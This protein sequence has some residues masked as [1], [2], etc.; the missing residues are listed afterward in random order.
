MVKE[1]KKIKQ[2]L[3]HIFLLWLLTSDNFSEA[4]YALCFLLVLLIFIILCRLISSFIIVGFIFNLTVCHINDEICSVT[5]FNN[6]DHI[7][8]KPL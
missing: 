8:C 3:K 4:L 7:F 2:K 1:K 5:I 6:L